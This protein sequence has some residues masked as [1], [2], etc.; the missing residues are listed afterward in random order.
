[1]REELNPYLLGSKFLQPAISSEVRKQFREKTISGAENLVQ[2]GAS[3]RGNMAMKA[4]LYQFF[5][6]RETKIL[7]NAD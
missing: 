1:M 6:G 4:D 5:I 3:I 7:L 2:Y